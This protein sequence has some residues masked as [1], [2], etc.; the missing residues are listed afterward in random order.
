MGRGQNKMAPE[1]AEWQCDFLGWLEEQKM[2]NSICD[3]GSGS[4][5]LDMKEKIS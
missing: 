3:G 1:K 4:S 2:S 5:Y